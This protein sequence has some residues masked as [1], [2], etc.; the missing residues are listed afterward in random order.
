MSTATKTTSTIGYVEQ[1][2]RFAVIDEDERLHTD[3]RPFC[4]DAS[5]PCHEDIELVQEHI[6]TPWLA[7]LLTNEEGERLHYGQQL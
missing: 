6:L 2:L 7:G 1:F 5:C 4:S 3:A